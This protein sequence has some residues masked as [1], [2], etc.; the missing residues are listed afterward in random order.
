MPALPTVDHIEGRSR[1]DTCGHNPANSPNNHV[2]RLNGAQQ[3]SHIPLPSVQ[4][5][6][7]LWLRPY[8]PFLPR[9]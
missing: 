9:L 3:L 1:R 8:Q 6:V 4:H 7:R 2:C 5:Q